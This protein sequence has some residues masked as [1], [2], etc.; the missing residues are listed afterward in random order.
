M[1]VLSHTGGLAFT[2]CYL[3]IDDTT[4][5]CVLFDAPDNTVEPVLDYVQREKLNLIGLW[6]THG[7]FDH[8]A[9][10]QVVRDRF[11]NV[12][13][14]IHREDEFMLRAPQAKLFQLPFTIPP[15]KADRL[16]EDGEKLSIGNLTCEVLFTPGH[17]PGHVCFYFES[18]KTLVGGDLIIGGAVGRT[19]LPGCD[20][21]DL[22]ESV[23]RI[24]R[25]PPDTTLLPGHGEPTTLGE[26]AQ[27]N[28]YVRGMIRAGRTA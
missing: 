18:D 19:D 17:A 16:I 26:E 10:H 22:A 12:Q 5:T 15:G 3:V 23:R 7:H 14:L 9:S 20:E 4:G 2:N 8:V 27:T 28:A 24:M 6:L 21:E 11:P 13:I 1:K 25:L